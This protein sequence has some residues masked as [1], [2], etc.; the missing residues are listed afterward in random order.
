LSYYDNHNHFWSSQ[1]V[2]S[3]SAQPLVNRKK[4]RLSIAARILTL[5][6]IAVWTPLLLQ[7]LVPATGENQQKSFLSTD[8]TDNQRLSLK[9][10]R[11]LL[12]LSAKQR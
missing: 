8:S 12:Y 9:R 1:T 4:T 11:F 3:Q 2:C 7:I 5:G 6:C 10:D